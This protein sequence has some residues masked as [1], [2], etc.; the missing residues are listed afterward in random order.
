[1]IIKSWIKK[2]NVYYI[3]VYAEVIEESARPSVD[4]SFFFLLSGPYTL[5]S[6]LSL[7]LSSPTFLLSLH[8]YVAHIYIFSLIF[9]SS[10]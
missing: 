10:T 7:S 8:Y 9:T 3:Q 6:L 4:L 1:M 2:D 5:Y